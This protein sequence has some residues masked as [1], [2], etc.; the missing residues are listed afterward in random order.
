MEQDLRRTHSE[1]P[2]AGPGRRPSRKDSLFA[3]GVGDENQRRNTSA[4][5]MAYRR[6]RQVQ[7]EKAHKLR[8]SVNMSPG[9]QALLTS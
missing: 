2:A 3:A 8:L 7:A 9:D 1:M 6:S 4:S 5:Q